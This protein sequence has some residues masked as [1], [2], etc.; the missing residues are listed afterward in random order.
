MTS[1]TQTSHD[2]NYSI[3][4]KVSTFFKIFSIRLIAMCETIGSARAAQHLFSQNCP[5]QA[6]S[7]MTNY[8]HSS[9]ER[10]QMIKELKK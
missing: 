5:E 2:T 1:I 7:V 6:R 3:S 4:E 8:L 9:E 10:K